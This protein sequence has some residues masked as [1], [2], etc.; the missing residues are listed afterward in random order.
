VKISVF[1]PCIP[2]HWVFIAGIA[3]A[4]ASGSVAPAEIVCFLSNAAGVA[5]DRRNING[6]RVITSNDLVH[7]GPA[8]QKALDLCS[9]DI[10]MYNDAEDIPHPQRVEIVK[11]EF[12]QNDIMHLTHSFAFI[13]EPKVGRIDKYASWGQ[14]KI[15]ETYFRNGRLTD[16]KVALSYGH[17]I[18]R[19][20]AGPCCIL[21]SVLKK[22]KWESSRNVRLHPLAKP[23]I[24]S[25]GEDYDFC[26][27]VAYMFRKSKMIDAKLIT[28]LNVD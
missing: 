1:I 27:K 7:A 24:M 5:T 22:V 4:Y 6:I 21:K 8:R 23:G 14:K 11:R 15:N 25:G 28:Y 13:N 3:A 20:T 2:R 16:C 26:M 12:E 10:I 9:G 17:H 18:A 19:Q